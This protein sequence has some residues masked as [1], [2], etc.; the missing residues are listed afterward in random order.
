MKQKKS[1]GKKVSK[2][3]LKPGKRHLRTLIVALAIAIFWRGIWGFMDLYFFPNMLPLSFALSI[4]FG[5]II[6]YSLKRSWKIL[7]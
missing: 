4:F 1:G 6:L 5:L 7:E 3:K 2:N